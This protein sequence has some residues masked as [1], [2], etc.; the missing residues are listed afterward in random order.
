MTTT[1][2]SAAGER[3]ARLQ[4]SG[5][6]EAEFFTREIADSFDGVMAKNRII[7]GGGLSNGAFTASVD[8]R[9]WT[10]TIWMRDNGAMLREL[11]HYGEFDA[12]K[13]LILALIRSVEPNADGFWTFPMFTKIGEKLS[14]DEWDGT[15]LIVVSAILL[16]ERLP[17]GDPVR[18][19]IE[20]FLLASASPVRA[21][22]ATLAKHQLVA[23]SGE[24]GGGLGLEGPFFNVVQNAMI[25]WMLDLAAARFRP[26]D[27]RA[28]E[29]SRQCARAAAALKIRVVSHFVGADQTWVWALNVD[30]A[31]PSAEAMTATANQGFG[32]VNGVF[33]HASDVHGVL[34]MVDAAPWVA[35]SL[36]TFLA[37]LARPRRLEQFSRHGMWTQFDLVHDGFITGPSYGQGYALQSMLLM[38]RP[39]FY[40]PAANWLARATFAPEYP[41]TREN[42]HW[43][44]ERYYSPDDP[45]RKTRDEGCGALNLVCVAEPLKVA[46]LMAG[47]DDHADDAVAIVPRLPLGWTGLH[48]E[49]VPVRTAAG[50]TLLD[51]AV[52][53][54]GVRG[55][56]L[57]VQ[58]KSA[59]PL[60]A[61]N[62][63][64]GT[65]VQPLWR[66]VAAGAREFDVGRDR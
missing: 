39:E 16:W 10:D 53:T 41:I 42:P 47:L 56:V 12:A 44:Y 15:A 35:P 30:T 63:R 50:H 49:A 14:G 36:R 3:R 48:A 51:F 8:G 57:R 28:G 11:V 45:L 20:E 37:L 38:D 5:C 17:A 54:D 31:E 6:K 18:K 13:A 60:P 27:G 59:A 4:F 55:A 34:P 19:Q 22:L 24:F 1:P 25:A 33:S 40:T 65:A 61:V 7:A 46:R 26:D 62:V 32:G 58:G 64:L 66:T 23:G 9:P 52:V 21:A 2:N 29:L 43:F